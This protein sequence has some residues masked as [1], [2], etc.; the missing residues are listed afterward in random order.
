M[1]TYAIQAEHLSKKYRIGSQPA[2]QRYVAL[3][4]VIANR[5]K[6][7]A[8][9]F[10]SVLKRSSHSD[11]AAAPSSV[12]H[13]EAFWALKDVSFDVAAGDV[14][15]IIG[16]NGAGKSTLLKI[17]SRITEP[18]TGRVR[19]NG[20]VASLLEVGTGFHPELTGRE[21]ILLNG[22]ILG[23]TRAEIRKNFDAIV[24]FAEVEKFL[25]TP[26]KRYS[27]GMYVRLAFAVAAHLQPEILI[28]D[29]VLA[30]G[31]AEFQRKCLG[32][33]QDVSRSGRT[34]LFVSH[35]MAAVRHLCTRGM[36]LVAG[37]LQA[38]GPIDRVVDAY[39]SAGSSSR[40]VE[41]RPVSK[42]GLELLELKLYAINS[43][44]PLSAAVFGRDYEIRFAVKGGVTDTRLSPVLSL[45]DEAG[46]RL[47][48]V[49]GPEE[50]LDFAPIRGTTAWTVCLP[51]LPL[52]PGRYSVSLHLYGLEP[53][54]Y[55][56][57]D[58]L[59]QFTVEG[60]LVPGAARAYRSDHGLI[61]ICSGMT[62]TEIGVG[63][64]LTAGDR[65]PTQIAL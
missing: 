5:I 50:G 60:A 6:R 62:V 21:N 27:S 44:V 8:T 3:R 17:L 36:Y 58:G 52:F 43:S 14:V 7:T 63:S 34:V 55:L 53:E 23:M 37:E 18:T 45:Y 51:A 4:D 46:R 33:M 13:T 26:V 31:D 2:G 20:R 22:A 49:C 12:S 54:P 35:N 59:L 19:L 24:A 16:R 41:V 57:A 47:S 9:A 65:A 61:R 32:K 25:D 30:V 56:E 40:M 48:T 15:G 10:S 64:E 1:S 29:E 28:V 39:L 38:I 42:N 11:T